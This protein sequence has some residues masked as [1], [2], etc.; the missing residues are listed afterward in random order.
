MEQN[1]RFNIIKYNLKELQH[2][3]G[4]KIVV[5]IEGTLEVIGAVYI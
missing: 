2:N 1:K 5:K 3:F 4:Q